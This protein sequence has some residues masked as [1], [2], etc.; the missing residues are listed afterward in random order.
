MNI[1]QEIGILLSTMSSVT[2]VCLIVGLV[3]I[4]VEIFQPGFGI[5]GILGALLCVVAILIHISAG[6]GNPLAQIFLLVFLICFFVTIAFL[7]MLSS[8]KKGWISRSP[9]IEKGRAVDV[10]ISE[11]TKDYSFLINMIGIASTDLRPIGRA[12]L[13][14]ETYDVIADGFFITKNEG[15]KVVAV[16]GVKITV[17]RAE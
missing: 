7:V 3:L 13:G 11:G 6:N 16:E 14:E 12:I 15:I 17:K 4:I 9:L 10:G 8:A 5:F 2:I 1:F